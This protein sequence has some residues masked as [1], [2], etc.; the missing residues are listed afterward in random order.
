MI[1]VNCSKNLRN[2]DSSYQLWI[3]ILQYDKQLATLCSYEAQAQGS[4]ETDCCQSCGLQL[5]GNDVATCK[6]Q[7]GN[8]IANYDLQPPNF[9][10]LPPMYTAGYMGCV[11]VCACMRACVCV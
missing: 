6:L 8:C 4:T 10:L 11:C 7:L 2:H 3:C 1:A 9:Q 5:D